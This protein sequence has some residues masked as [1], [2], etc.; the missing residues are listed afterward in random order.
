MQSLDSFQ[1]FIAHHTLY[2]Y[3]RNSNLN[4]CNFIIHDDDDADDFER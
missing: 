3:P 2:A 4:I 1:T